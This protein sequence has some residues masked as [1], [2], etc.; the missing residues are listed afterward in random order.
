MV[1]RQGARTRAPRCESSLK[2]QQLHCEFSA[3][4][5]RLSGTSSPADTAH[6][7]L[8]LPRLLFPRVQS[9]LNE[10]SVWLI[11][12]CYA[13]CFPCRLKKV[14]LRQRLLH[15]KVFP[16]G[17]E[18][19]DVTKLILLA[20]LLM[21]M[22]IFHC[23]QGKLYIGTDYIKKAGILVSQNKAIHLRRA[24]WSVSEGTATFEPQGRCSP[25]ASELTA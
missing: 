1:N 4:R 3:G 21:M 17:T 14:I 20:I 24:R 25:R 5:R 16:F 8:P 22:Q 15:C 9:S 11:A 12:C 7:P 6:S 18:R 13:V 23:L 10:N 2:N 19:C